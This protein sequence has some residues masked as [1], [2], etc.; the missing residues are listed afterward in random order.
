MDDNST[1]RGIMKT[2]VK[3]PVKVTGD[4]LLILEFTY[5]LFI[6]LCSVSF[7]MTA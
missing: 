7:N 3:M 5:S 4:G 6:G 1:V 2:S